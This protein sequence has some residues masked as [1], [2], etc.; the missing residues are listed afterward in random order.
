[1]ILKTM[2]IHHFKGIEHVVIPNCGP[3]NALVGKNNSG[4]S[5]VLQA[6]DMAGLALSVG[7]WDYFQPKLEIKDLF[8]DGGDFRVDLTYTS[9]KQISISTRGKSA[10]SFVPA[11]G[12][13]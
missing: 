13:D 10:P 9:D 11:P 2:D 5:S 6:I 3:I 7:R 1:M 12:E 8:W 4:K